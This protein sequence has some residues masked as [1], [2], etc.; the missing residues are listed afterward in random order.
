MINGNTEAFEQ[1]R[2]T[3]NKDVIANLHFEDNQLKEELQTFFE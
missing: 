3:M 2:K 1:L